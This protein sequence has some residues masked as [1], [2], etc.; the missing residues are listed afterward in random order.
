MPTDGDEELGQVPARP[1]AELVRFVCGL[2]TFFVATRVGDVPVNRK[3][4]VGQ[5][6]DGIPTLTAEAKDAVHPIEHLPTLG[7]LGFHERTK[8][9]LLPFVVAEREL[10][11]ARFQNEVEGILLDD[12]KRHPATKRERR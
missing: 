6:R 7:H 4:E 11:G 2:S 10:P 5:K 8:R 1:L 3:V 12:V 9:A